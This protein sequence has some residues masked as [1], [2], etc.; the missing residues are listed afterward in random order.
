MSTINHI[1]PE[2]LSQ[3][4]KPAA[5]GLLI[6]TSDNQFLLTKR[7]SNAHYLAGH[8][9]VPSGESNVNE[10]ESMESC[11][12]REFKEETTHEIPE[13]AKLICIDRYYADERMYFLFF[14]RVK[15]KF[16]VKIDWEHEAV[17]WFKPDNLPEP[18][19][20]QILDAIQRIPYL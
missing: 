17:G 3:I 20:P 11:A 13:R 1:T 15:E 9:S 8:W 10:L 12:R 14:H 2:Q 18:I 4:R 5:A 6:A 7:T 16:F 19:A